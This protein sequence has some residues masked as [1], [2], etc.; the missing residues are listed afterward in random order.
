MSS[1]PVPNG[2]P[3]ANTSGKEGG[4]EEQRQD[5]L[6]LQTCASD[7]GSARKAKD[8]IIYIEN[9][10]HTIPP[11]VVQEISTVEELLQKLSYKYPNMCNDTIG[12]RVYDKKIGSMN[13]V[14]YFETLPL[15]VDSLYLSLYLKRHPP[16]PVR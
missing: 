10:H 13:R 6:Q 1:E 5:D 14:S 4:K 15:D 7:G 3:A 12:L 8:Y 16:L 2:Q 11:F 9:S